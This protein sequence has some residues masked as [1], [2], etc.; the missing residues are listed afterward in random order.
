MAKVLM[1]ASEAVPFVKTG[2]LAD[3]VDGLAS[4]LAAGGE[5]V[6]VLLPKYRAVQPDGLERVY[7][8]LPV[9]LGSARYLVGIDR[10]RRN[11]VQ[12]L[13]ADCPTL[14]DRPGIYNEKNIDYPD[15]HIRFAV[16]CKAALGVVRHLYRPQILHLHDWQASLTAAYARY[17]LDRDPTFF[18]VR[19]L[20]TIHNLGY[21]GIFP[22][23]ALPEIGLDERVFRADA[24]EFYG[25]INSLKAGIV[26][27]D[28]INTVSPTYAR[29]I[30]TPDYGFGLDGLLRTRSDRIFGVL[31]GVDYSEW[32]PDHDRHLTRPYSASDLEGKSASKQALLEEFG[33][34]RQNLDRPLIG[35]VSRLADQKGFDLIA[36]VQA[37]L[38]REDV[39]LAVLGAGDP[40]YENMFLN[41]ARLH[42]D[43]V[44]VLIGYDEALAHRIEAGADIFLMPSRYE[45][46]GL[47]QLY[48][49]RYGTIPVVRATGGLNDTIDEETGFKF[50]EYSGRALMTAIHA[51]L[52]AYRSVGQWRTRM[53]RGMEKDFSWGVAA[54][55]YAELYR[56]L[57]GVG[58]AALHP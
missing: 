20:L 23:A 52:E 3:M 39:G 9:W 11:G 6:A 36:E 19:L 48:S 13:F 50:E 30:Q 44:G 54:S 57:I 21:Q 17:L 8:D 29:E 46:C 32:S 7:H 42:P 53:R 25:Q 58:R 43:R 56:R 24:L 51:A 49:L 45:P 31:N 33:L 55:R 22:H 41:L 37:Q 12:Y 14:Y 5:D 47:N 35:I 2:G 18:A 16:L 28:A 34:A 27:S 38:M 40:D 4:A 1:V 26:W 10:V 15:N